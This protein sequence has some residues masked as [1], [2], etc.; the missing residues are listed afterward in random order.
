M[1]KTNL[2]CRPAGRF[3]GNYVVSMRPFKGVD[4][5]RV[6]ELTSR[7]PFAHGAPL[8]IG[9]P[10]SIGIKDINKPD[11]GEPV[12]IADDE[13]CVF[14][15]CGVTSQEAILNSGVDMAIVHSPGCMFVTDTIIDH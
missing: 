7:Y 12:F 13:I 10:K 2:V 4:I 1:F 6:V 3:S 14:H 8:H 9:S 15:A 11:F 5:A